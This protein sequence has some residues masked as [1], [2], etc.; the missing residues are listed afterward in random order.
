MS[1]VITEG[2][3]HQG[4][5]DGLW[6]LRYPLSQKLICMQWLFNNQCGGREP[7][8]PRVKYWPRLLT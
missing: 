1:R 6:S 2:P 5:V 4:T 8:K 3:E 7:W